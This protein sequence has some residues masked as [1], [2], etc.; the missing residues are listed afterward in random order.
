VLDEVV[1]TLASR[2]SPLVLDVSVV[3]DTTFQP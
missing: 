2:D 3:A 1:P